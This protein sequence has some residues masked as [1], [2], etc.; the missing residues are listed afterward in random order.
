M[1]GG[2]GQQPVGHGR[3]LG[4]QG[5]VQVGADDVV[6][7][8][9]LGG[10]LAV[11]AVAHLHGAE[12]ACA[13]P[14]GGQAGVVLIADDR[15]EVLG[16][17]GDVADEA[18]IA[19]HRMGVHEADTG[20]L[21]ALGGGEAV[22]EELVEAADRQ[23][24]DAV[25]RPR[26]EGGADCDQVLLDAV[27]TG[28]LAAAAHEDVDVARQLVARVVGEQLDVVALPLGAPRQYERVAPV[29]VDVHVPRV[30]LEQAQVPAGGAVSGVLVARGHDM[31]SSTSVISPRIERRASIAV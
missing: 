27:L 21:L 10:V 19:G 15:A 7:A 14:Q 30:E 12:G 23:H 1:L 11:V 4:Q 26:L 13:R 2:A 17:Q 9:A 20:D 16:V 18:G 29:A 31:T 28:V 5:A 24:R 22:P 8:P 3:V 25:G 6:D